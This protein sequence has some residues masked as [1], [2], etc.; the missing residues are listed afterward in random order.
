MSEGD[1]CKGV[2]W[3]RL[4]SGPRDDASAQILAISFGA[5][6]PAI[7]ELVGDSKCG[8]LV[9]AAVFIMGW[10]LAI[11]RTNRRF[12]LR[13]ILVFT[14]AFA[15]LLGLLSWLLRRYAA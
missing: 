5:Q 14:T 11:A 12:G 4:A 3:C 7:A 2:R 10:A 15:V 13:T 6:S 1:N 8:L 9:V